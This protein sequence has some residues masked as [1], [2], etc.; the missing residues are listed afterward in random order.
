MCWTRAY[1]SRA[2]LIGLRRRAKSLE[3][4]QVAS[5]RARHKDPWLE[6]VMVSYHFRY[7]ACDHGS[8]S[9]QAHQ[10]I[11]HEPLKLGFVVLG[12]PLQLLGIKNRKGQS[13]FVQYKI[14]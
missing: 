13:S 11:K 9:S 10:S 8:H 1:K 7:Q 4:G 12:S 2:Q 14:H 3:F 6:A 5:F